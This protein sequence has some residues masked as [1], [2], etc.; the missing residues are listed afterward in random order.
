[1]SRLGWVSGSLLA[2]FA[3]AGCGARSSSNAVADSA[4]KTSAA[5]SS[6]LEL[7]VRQENE[8]ADRFGGVYDYER[9]V[10]RFAS[11]SG[12]KEG[13]DE[14][15]IQVLYTEDASYM[16]LGAFHTKTGK[17]WLKSSMGEGEL[18]PPFASTPADLLRFLRAASEVEK[19]DSGEVRGVEALHYRARLDLDRA[20]DAVP[21]KD[22]E[23]VR[24]MFSA[25]WV[26]QKQVP[27][28]LWIDG[29][30]RLRR[31][32]IEIP[33]GQGPSSELTLD[34][35][36]YGVAV[37][38]KPPPADQVI[39]EDEFTQLLVGECNPPTRLQNEKENGEGGLQLCVG[40]E[41]ELK[42]ETGVTTQP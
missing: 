20:V 34:V 2:A 11:T 38:V 9:S 3:L 12:A 41:S 14:G 35:F 26:D 16:N 32:Q 21:K 33:E 39:T 31:V 27:F 17:R 23:D 28:D 40:A 30:G 6:R 18:F 37:D 5:R 4:D 36:D 15:S 1:M 25:Y 8:P 24:E 7:V 22:R 19:V 42:T 13:E 10:G 29:E